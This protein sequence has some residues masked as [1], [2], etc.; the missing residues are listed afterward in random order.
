MKISEKQFKIGVIVFVLS[1]LTIAFGSVFGIFH[2]D[3]TDVAAGAGAA[4]HSIGTVLLF[5]AVYWYVMASKDALPL[6]KKTPSPAFVNIV[7]GLLVVLS[8]LFY[9]GFYIGQYK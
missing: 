4:N 8:L 1:V 7:L 9:T 2:T 6:F 3:I 5:A